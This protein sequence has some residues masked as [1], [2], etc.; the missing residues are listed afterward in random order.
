MGFQKTRL[1]KGSKAAPQLKEL[2]EFGALLKAGMLGVVRADSRSRFAPRGQ[3]LA[4]AHRGR[5]LPCTG[6]HGD[7]DRRL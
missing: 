4:G 7:G 3:V 2:E 1:A 5:S 6:G